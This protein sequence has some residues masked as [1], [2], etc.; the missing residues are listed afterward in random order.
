MEIFKYT[1]KSRENKSTM[2]SPVVIIQLQ[3]AQGHF[4][5]IST[6]HHSLLQLLSSEKKKTVLN[7]YTE[8]NP[9]IGSIKD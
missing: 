3:S 4:C 9:K 5:F 8:K 1:Q 2:G 7:K 6:S